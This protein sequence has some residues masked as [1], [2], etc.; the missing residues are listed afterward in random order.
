ME[1]KH[2]EKVVVM[3]ARKRQRREPPHD[4]QEIKQYTLWPEQET[5]ERLRPI[6]LFGQTAAERAKETGAGERTL[7]SQANLFE[8]EG[9]ASLFHKPRPPDT[10]PSRG[11]PPELCQLIV[12]LKA[13]YPGFSLREISTICFLRFGRKLS[14]HTVQRVLADGGTPQVSERRYPPYTQIADPYQ[15]RR[16]IVDLHAQGW[17]NT[18]ISA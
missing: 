1:G 10:E 17:S 12:N 16:A 3:P 6:V 8:Q 14:H 11:L 4:W 13:E 9:M 5:Y 18:A 2:S 7:H 15:R